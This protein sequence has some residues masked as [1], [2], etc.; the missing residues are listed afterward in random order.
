MDQTKQKVVLLTGA[1]SGIGE[2]TAI[3]LRD[4]GFIVYAAARRVERMSGLQE[5]G[6]H[7]LK[8]DVTD[9]TSMV[10][11]VESILK[12]TGRIDILINNAGYGSYGALEDVPLAEA[13][14]NSKSI[15]SGWRA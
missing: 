11:G 8:M 1:S 7:V 4:S 15:S 10:A 2:A 5:R 3:R 14:A 12:E 9:D 13:N 6:V